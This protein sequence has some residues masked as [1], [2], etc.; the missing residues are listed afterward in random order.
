MKGRLHK[1]P[2]PAFLLAQSPL[3]SPC[4]FSKQCYIYTETHQHRYFFPEDG[5]IMY[6]RNVSNIAHNYAL[7]QPENRI[8]VR[9][10]LVRSKTCTI[11][12]YIFIY[13]YS[14]S[15]DF[16]EGESEL[17]SGFNVAYRFSTKQSYG[18]IISVGC[19]IGPYSNL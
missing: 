6:L 4:S 13:P 8:Y 15:F 1:P 5:G 16:A 12:L 9:K 14:D 7:L 17:A 11:M 18:E 2:G 3:Y 19:M 10:A